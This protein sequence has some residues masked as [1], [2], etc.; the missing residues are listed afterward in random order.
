MANVTA[1]KPAAANSAPLFSEFIITAR[2]SPAIQLLI[3]ES[4]SRA[5][6]IGVPMKAKNYEV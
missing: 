6:M 3:V 5:P 4:T 2:R 1:T